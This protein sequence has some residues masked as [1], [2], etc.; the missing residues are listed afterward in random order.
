[1][2]QGPAITYGA[3][4]AQHT[5][6]AVESSA[7]F[8]SA[9]LST[10]AVDAVHAAQARRTSAGQPTLGV[11]GPSRAQSTGSAGSGAAGSATIGRLSGCLNL[12]AAART[13][14]LVDI[15][16]FEH[17]PATIIVL[18][19]TASAPAEALIVGSSCSATD[20]DVLVHAVLSHL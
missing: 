9:S 12:I 11:P 5:I 17:K 6:Q 1:M 8:A 13:V 18:A 7:N 2:S 16:R 19:A 15:A 4:K 14:L 20:R 3:P 10:Q